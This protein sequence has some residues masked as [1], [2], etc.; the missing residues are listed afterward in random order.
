MLQKLS[1]ISDENLDICR[2]S[3]IYFLIWKCVK[4][5]NVLLYIWSVHI[6][7]DF[8]IDNFENKRNT[9][10]INFI[11]CFMYAYIQKTKW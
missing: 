5:L 8:K 3:A 4:K 11:S 9:L 6:Q 2:L 7:A 10:L 1:E